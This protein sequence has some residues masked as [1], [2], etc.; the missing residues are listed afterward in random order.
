MY[1]VFANSVGMDDDQ[2]KNSCAMVLDPFG[3]MLA[4]CQELCEGMAV[5]LCRQE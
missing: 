4:E 2:L 5:A 1:V 3:D